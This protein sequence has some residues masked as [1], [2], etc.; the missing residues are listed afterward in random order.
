MKTQQLKSIFLCLLTSA[1]CLQ[2]TNAQIVYTDV[3]PDVTVSTNGGVYHLDLNNDGITDF[4]I[5]YTTST[6]GSNCGPVT[7]RYIRITPL[8]AN[9]VGNNSSYPGAVS[10]NTPIGGNFFNWKNNANQILFDGPCG[11]FTWG[12]T[13]YHIFCGHIGNW[14]VGNAYLPLRINVNS[15]KYYGWAYLYIAPY[16]VSFTVRSYAYNSIYNLPI[17]AGE[18][19]CT[20]TPTVTLSANGP[21]SFCAGDSVTLT[22]NGTGYQYVWKKNGGVN[23]SGATSQTYV[24]KTAATYT[25]KV[26]NSCGSITSAGIIVSVP[27]LPVNPPGNRNQVVDE[28]SNAP[29]LLISPN[30]LTNSTTISLSLS[31][32]QK[33]SLKIFDV[34]RRL[35]TTL[36]DKIFE[37]GEIELVWNAMDVNAG[38]YLLKIQTEEFMK[39]EKIIV[40]KK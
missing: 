33:V 39:M 38:I 9:E 18:T 4:N 37:A 24:A 14:L 22:A 36:A 1:F 21:L 31:Q 3:N 8:G 40:T 13:G 23:I 19:F 20:T 17:R 7:S 27:C 32:S 30:P 12:G 25:C 6:S 16:A 35:I 34:N 2:K 29:P 5:T 15:Q 11:C 28:F 10:F 26:S